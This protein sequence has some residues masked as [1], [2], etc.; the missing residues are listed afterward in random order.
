M[1]K[2]LKLFLSKRNNRVF[3][4]IALVA[5]KKKPLFMKGLHTN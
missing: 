1:Q 5:P 4:G 3:Q 2:L